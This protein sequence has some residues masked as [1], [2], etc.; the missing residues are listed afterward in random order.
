MARKVYVN[1]KVRLVVV[2]NDDANVNQVLQDMEYDFRD[3]SG[4]ADIVDTE[5]VDWE[6]ADA[7]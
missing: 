2:A 7:K 5:I 6:I 4:E 1:L 3:Q